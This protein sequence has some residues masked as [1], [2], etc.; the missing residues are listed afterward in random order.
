MY[1]KTIYLPITIESK[2]KLLLVAQS[3]GWVSN[4]ELTEEEN[5]ANAEAMCLE[6]YRKVMVEQLADPFI[7]YKLKNDLENYRKQIV[8]ESTALAEQAVGQ[9]EE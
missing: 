5:L 4:P 8:E 3:K 1:P 6:F 9:P 7:Q 2:E